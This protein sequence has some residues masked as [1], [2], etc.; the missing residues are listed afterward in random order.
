MNNDDDDGTAIMLYSITLKR[1]INYNLS[2]VN[3]YS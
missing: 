3:S 2:L 1:L